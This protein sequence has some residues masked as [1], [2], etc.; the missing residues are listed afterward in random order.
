MKVLGERDA[1]KNRA[2][3]ATRQMRTQPTLHAQ[4]WANISRA[5]ITLG[6]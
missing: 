1:S 4:R 3:P 2:D 5:C 6:T